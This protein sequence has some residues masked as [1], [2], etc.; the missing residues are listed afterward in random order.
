MTDNAADQERLRTYLRKAAADLS[1]ADRRVRELEDRDREPIAIVGMS[2]RYPGGVSSP[3]QLW[4]L[5]IAGTDAI[6]EFPDDRGW[7]LERLFDPDPDSP[8]T[9]YA[10]H[11]GFLE[12]VGDFDADFFGIGPREALAMDPQQRLMLEGAWE[13]FE[14]AG[15]DPTTLVGTQTG[16]FT[17]VMYQDYGLNA[18]PVSAELE[19]Y[20]GT[21]SAPSVISGRVAY[22]YGLEGPAVTVD[23]ACSSSLVALHSACQ[24][25]RSGECSL[26]LAGGVTVL[27]TPNVYISFA[28]QRG[29]SVDGRCKS[30]GAGADGAGFS[31]GAGLLLLE[32]LSDA[33]RNG[34]DVLAVIRGSA[35]NQDGASNGLTAPNGPSQQR[36][37][38]QALD[39]VGLSPAEVDAVEAHGTGTTLGDPIEAQA[40]LATYGQDRPDDR[41]LWLGSVKSN[42]G[43][44][45]AAAG[46]AGVIKMVMAM[47]NGVLPRTLHADEPSPHVDWSEGDISLLKEPVPWRANGRPRR[48]GVSSFGVSGTNAHVV[49][50]EA[51]R[52]Q[53]ASAAEGEV[54]VEVEV[55]T[56]V[57]AE[58]LPLAITPCLLSGASAEALAGQAQRLLSFVSE[59]G[60]LDLHGVGC[61]LALRRGSLS[62]RA[63]VLAEGPEDL[64]ASLRALE[65]GEIVDGAVSGAV[66]SKGRSAFLFS[67]Q[68]SQWAGMGRALYEAF[69]VFANELDLL[70]GELDPLLGCSLQQLLF[71]LDGSSEDNSRLDQTQ[72]TQPALFALEVAL[73]RL[74]CSF[75]LKPDFLIGH[76]IGELSAA[77]VAGV[78]SLADAC[79][80]VV[81]RGRLMG[82][83]D[84]AGGMAAVRA[85]EQ[86]VIQSLTG[87]EDR[88]SLAAVNAPDAVVV[89]GDQT[90]L[91][92]WEAA[93]GEVE[94]AAQ[95]KI[96][97][98]RVSNAFHSA[99]MDPML[100]EFRTLAESIAFA[101]P[102]IPI[103]SNVTGEPAGS[104]LC[105]A[106]YWVSQVR[107]T[108]RF[109]DGIRSLREA[110]VTRFLEL[111]PDG[112]LSG[113]AHECIGAQEEDRDAMLVAA[114]LRKRRGEVAAFLGFLAQAHVHGIDVDWGEIF[115]ADSVER[116]TLPRYAF[117]R[118]RYWLPSVASATD[119]S[120]LGQFSAEHPLLGAALHLAG[121][122]DG[123][124]FTGRLAAED[125][126]WLKDHEIMGSVLMPGTGFVELALAVGQRVGSEVIDEL[127]LGAPLLLAGEGVRL[128]VTISE[129]DAQGRREIE[130]YSRSLDD[131]GTELGEEVGWTMHASGAL[132][133]GE[134]A[135]DSVSD[136][137]ATGTWPPPEAK[138]LATE[139][140]YER[141]AE[142]G[143]DYGPAF[144][145][146]QRVFEVGDELF[147]EVALEE[148]HAGEAQ[149]FCVHPALSDAALHAG[150]LSSRGEG[151]GVPFAFSDVHLYGRGAASLRVRLVGDGADPSTLSLS[152]VDEQGDPVFSV[153]TLRT[154]TIEQSQ[155]QASSRARGEELY[156]LEWVEVPSVGSAAPGRIAAL[157]DGEAPHPA[158]AAIGIEPGSGYPHLTGLKAALSQGAPAPDTVLVD[159]GTKMSPRKA[160]DSGLAGITRDVVAQA[161]ELSQEWIAAEGLSD[162][163]L[164]FV[165]ENALV[166]S[167][168]DDPNLAQAALA[169]L[170]RSAQSEHPGRFAVIDLDHNEAS[171]GA[172]MDALSLGESELAV[173]DGVPLAP[174]LAR[175][176]AGGS[177]IAPPEGVP[178]RMGTSSP[179]TL[180]G[181]K[182][183]ESEAAGDALEAGQVRIAMHAAGLN[184]RDV[185]IALGMYPGEA[186]IGGEG[187]G[188]VLE[189]A[190]DVS[191]LVVG[192]RVMGLMS[193][194]FGPIAV[195]DARYLVK[196]PEEWSFIQAASV[197]IVFLTAYYGMSDLAELKAGERLLVHGAA[198]GV[199]T[200][201]LQLAHYF[202]AEVFATA[203]PDKWGALEDLGVE[204]TH[205][206]SSRTLEFK[207]KF[208]GLTDGE[209]VD[210][211]LD[212]LAGEFV[213]ASLE[214]LPGGGRFLEMGKTDIRDPDEV[215]AKHEGVR[216][217]AFDL[218]E[219]PAER[220]QEMLREL[221]SL[222]ERGVL[223][224][225]PITVEDVRHGVEA[226]RV[227]R[228]S[229]HIGKL[230]L[231]IPQPFAPHGT[232]LITGGTG[233]LGAL[234]ARHLATEHRAERL[235]LVSRRGIE[236][237]GARELGEAL[238]ELGCEAQIAACDVADREQLRELIDS[239]PEE[240]P[241]TM[242]IHA[243]GVLDD[244]LIE[245]LDSE[246]LSRVF[247]PKVDAA[248]NL[249]ELTR[250]SSE[251]REFVLFSSIASSMGSPG[252]GNYAAANAFLDALAAH[253]RAQGLPGV[254]L[255]WSAWDQ[256]VGMTG[257]LG[258]SER[259]RF[260][261]IGIVPLSQDQGLELFDLA[262]GVDA[263][264]LLPVPLQ[265]TVLRGQA[266]AGM[267]PAILRGLVRTPIRRASDA[268]GSLARRLATLPR[269]EWA[270]VV[271]ALVGEHVA[272]VLGHTSAT[273]I[274]PERA[275]KD[276]GF[277]SL[278][279]VELRNRLT[280]AT[281]LRLPSTLV[282]DHPTPRAVAEFVLESVHGAGVRSEGEVTTLGR[283]DRQSDEPIAIVGMS[284]RYPGGVNSPQG[285]WDLVAG[286]VDGIGEFPDNRGWRLEGLFDPDP[287][288]PGTS[289]T[290]HGGF[291]YDAGE[292]DAEFFGISPREALAMDPQ[293]RLA[294][295]GAWE[296]FEDA[297]IDPASL[298]GSRTGVFAGSGSTVYGLGAHPPELE[299]LRLTGTTG[300]VASGRL[301]YTFGLEGPAVTVDTAC[302]SSLVAL[303]LA[304]QSLRSGE[305]SMALAGGVTVM[306]SPDLFIEFSRQRGL[307]PDG[308]CK[309]FGAQADGTG[310]SEG[311]G[312]LL[313]QRLSDAQRDGHDV[314][315]V[316]RGS[317]VNQD[318]ASN[319]LTAPNGP[320]QQ[321]VIRQ[322]LSAV[323]LAV[324]EVDAVEAH[325]TGTTLGDPIEAQAL[326]A[327]Y[328][329][330]R[331]DGRPLWL[332]S[333]KS[334][335]GHTLT[336]AGVAGVIKMVM[337]MR[338]EVLP[339][340]L[341]A[342]EPSPHVDWSAGDVALLTEP[343]SWQANGRPRRAGVSSFGISGTNAH[344]I[345]EEAPPVTDAR[346]A[347]NDEI[348][349]SGAGEPVSI[350]VTPC[351]VSAAS[352]GALAGQVGRLRAFVEDQPELDVYEI[353]S[354]LALRRGSLSHRAVILAEG[355]EDLLAGLA[356]F[357]RDGIVDGVLSGVAVGTGRLAFLFSGQGSQWAGMGRGLY[358]GFPRFANEFDALCA[359]LD[360]LIGCSLRELLFANDG[361]DEAA[362]L[363]VTE[364]TQPGLFAFEVALYRL[365]SSFG[366]QPD[367]LVGHSIGEFS[368]AYVAG[369]FSLED[370]CRLV[371]ARGRLMGALDGVGAMAAVRASEQLVSESLAAFDDRLSL[372]AVNAPEA[373]VVS[374][375]ETALEEWEA[376]FSESDAG[377]QR[378]ITRL[379]V[380]NAFHS[381]LMDPMLG[382]F[383]ALAEDVSF[384][385]P[386]IP[387]VSNVTGTVVGDELCNAEY[388]VSQVRGT[389]RF[390]DGVKCL[391]DAG[392]TRY[393]ELG[394][395]GVLSGMALECLGEKDGEYEDVLV[396]VS[397][398]KRRH[399]GSA[400]LSFLAQAHVHGVEID[401]G[402]F[403]D[404][405]RAKG[406]ALPTYAFQRSRYWL[407][408]E[409]G[410]T[411]AL[412]LGQSSAEH[413]MLGAALHLA[414][415]DDEGWIFTGRLS[416][417]T[418][419]W[420]KDHAVMD[421]VL[422]PGTGFVELALAAGQRVGTEAVEELTLYAP[423]LLNEGEAVQLQV[424]VSEPD[425]EGHRELAIYSCPQQEYEDELGK[426]W[427]RHAAGILCAG[428]DVPS[429]QAHGPEGEWPPPGAQELDSEFFYDRLAEAGYGYGPSFQG[430]RSAFETSE[431]IFAEVALD[432]EC[433]SEAHAFCVHP[434]LSDS[435]LHAALLSAGQSGEVGV[436]FSFSG[437]RLFGR[438]ASALRVRL[439]RDAQ[440]AQT[441]ILSAVDEQG[442]PAFTIT[443]LQTRAIDQNQLQ[444]TRSGGH[445]SL[446]ELAWGEIS[447][448]SPNGSRPHVAV[449]DATAPTGVLVSGSEF[450]SHAELADLELAIEQGASVPEVV[451]LHVAGTL[452]EQTD[453]N[454][455]GPGASAEGTAEIVRQIAEG[456]LG[457][458]QSFLACEPLLQARLLL[459]TDRAVAV[460][461]EE[462]PNLLQ[463]ALVGLLRS[464]QSEHPGRFGVIDLDGGEVARDALYAALAT[465][466]SEL[467]IRRDSLYA[468]RLTRVR[469]QE[470]TSSP[471]DSLPELRFGGT[472]LITGGTGGLGALMA[473]HLVKER[474]AERLLLAS[475]RGSEADGAGDLE[476]ELRELGCDVRIVACDASDRTQVV[477]L[478]GS[479][480]D[481][482]PLSAVIHAAGVLDDGVIESLDGER[483]SRVMVPK[484][485]GALNLHELAGR[486]ELIF[487]SS[488]A[489]TV[490][491]PGQGNYAAANAFLDGLAQHR[492]ASGLPGMS[493]AWGA[494]D[495]AAGMTGELSTGDRAR[496]ARMGMKPLTREQGLELFDLARIQKLPVLVPMGLDTAALRAQ[497]KTG[498][499]PAVLRTL[500]RVPTRRASDT[501]GSLAA[502]LAQTPES[503]WDN[504]IG[505]LVR[506]QVADV[507]GH[508]SVAAVDPQRPFQELGF[509]SLA[510]VELKNR[511]GRAS[512]LK[513]PSTLIF[514]HPTPG[515][516]A[517]YI[518]GAI[519]P[520][521]DRQSGLEPGEREIRELLTSI[522]LSQLR[523]AGLMEALME[524]AGGDGEASL[525]AEADRIDALD[526]AGLVQRSFEKQDDFEAHAVESDEWGL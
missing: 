411:D 519:T 441:M 389:V 462:T 112:V 70:C 173:R 141:L 516:V 311:M 381:A 307:S 73:Y 322:A 318:G 509:D 120:S 437:V 129:A 109:A 281:G 275:F 216:Y 272:G 56:T 198:G 51:P 309:S 337:A 235:L 361:S 418:H 82:A 409:A 425:P 226:F 224:H 158:I 98:L 306:T 451:L 75:G 11:G 444:S 376:R 177:L 39:G 81:G 135:H 30:F 456:V 469:V 439:S 264:L 228:E 351:L 119:A 237:E 429:L 95:R 382:E 496:L 92:E 176:G 463:A 180:D 138:Q 374:G 65:R 319:G 229:K 239:I 350:G 476:A 31:E 356:G 324:D 383:E 375:E 434:A 401:W 148:D 76:S 503:E 512:G 108:V 320:S 68:G 360:P 191:D 145:G 199:G 338:H 328:G 498:L 416:T 3:Q 467:A 478:L 245:S 339:K 413:P 384:T 90:A 461:E 277:D 48:A 57:A 392:V 378:K 130:I 107:G 494:W 481:E 217:R 268:G 479:V 394:P 408:P 96:T 15:I 189:V 71:A 436:P 52:V 501:K 14:D 10:R 380:S 273:A 474:G 221:V 121:E 44:T 419:P 234:V 412:S 113:L 254:S 368:A 402:A 438:G 345:L 303:H 447:T 106:E 262:R 422:M 293:Q 89:S 497:A 134:Q 220:V 346:G 313:L 36:V 187:A 210:V 115:H 390:A 17:G 139:D 515:A 331:P 431:E 122:E 414:G 144:R 417:E 196:M 66:A 391:R 270:G 483:L 137:F 47:R 94:G 433:A 133:S 486:A 172:L 406:V 349:V 332:G 305:C 205:I 491:S 278:A 502:K 379:R 219:A 253:R 43:H 19:G 364:F 188:V 421:S 143:Y 127:T 28:R 9:S 4:E 69:P 298:A 100:E 428:E 405:R 142:E 34:H 355:R 526:V 55:D 388:W 170:V 366:L 386:A 233:G 440:D 77:H 514:D 354:A 302:S 329:Q 415:E 460:A 259:A 58:R 445:D 13:A 207:D 370:A 427:T 283:P 385:E 22:S 252:Q 398:R 42:I 458:V 326:L 484:V 185:L 341:H 362:R 159:V 203:H 373:V 72:F 167:R 396:A 200:A 49:L 164:V 46:V 359:E 153:G 500:I 50:E 367:F 204:Q 347:A 296:A 38:R 300:S 238:A 505:E 99:L 269:S 448:P 450:E 280:T 504:L 342:E 279:A 166:A 513:L 91:G 212:S 154:R 20:L 335:I 453:G 321:R 285:L 54:E 288:S 518:R 393:L 149:R 430:L 471:E 452:A 62:H 223:K 473:R 85:S 157:G 209:G 499:L 248:V 465:E 521:D 12:D 64:L 282:F 357:E 446:Y 241:L 480:A 152:A 487:F 507:L 261:R 37:I 131:A 156:E 240:H 284:C 420:L 323:G 517:T 286:G 333:I 61:E 316:V 334:N 35:V 25:L 424:T 182:L 140:F 192:D 59:A 88:L 202:G 105:N 2:C 222:F 488:A 292:F 403:F 32:R 485:D 271:A 289:Y 511:L 193:D 464:A 41:P 454:G 407:S 215:A 225:P 116:V 387:I 146:L 178:W 489:A 330:D 291:L 399:E 343:V 214:L 60:A 29:L 7:G 18:G 470:K 87:F 495:Q 117:Q 247:A 520:R 53:G 150:L 26:A 255:G 348:V 400:F 174:R 449:L 299:G 213:D 290:R 124:V 184:F 21:G 493:L 265:M 194:A 263:P 97:R 295:E 244:G 27:S 377:A 325:G 426:E 397:L 183:L 276:L 155:L 6:S 83:L 257:T 256:A 423:L 186:P 230:V 136:M 258:E 93:F 525:S 243:A 232:V 404:V 125:H 16:V 151:V 45:Q 33:H 110:G 208:L 524:L 78:F 472:V 211:V 169:G 308:R 482:H 236:A 84:G 432:G 63:V 5:V 171:R 246:R 492:R 251:V 287:D 506:A 344:V 162:S 201:A 103:V 352:A 227:L 242:V 475:R 443:A 327:T 340:T 477:D 442:E 314:L 197:P 297:G 468:P 23:T 123:W 168:N 74:A 179:G 161:L 250:Q 372:A 317:A 195:A 274:D 260:E 1:R 118:R 410:T 128:Q 353:A 114:S 304:C 358:D 294:L 181:L 40:L 365:V 111:G 457:S 132:R 455:R 24:A 190:E 312:M 301:A 490:G 79:R 206:S 147:A 336:A 508:A 522:P 249:H 101:E 80:L 510:A 86:E 435:A 371:A 369:V 266:K 523:Q 466:E 310:W 267:L 315:A 126:P 459:V 104:Q 231:S 8:G 175:L 165:T 102:A 163:R 395:D 218:L 67:G 363:D 160:T